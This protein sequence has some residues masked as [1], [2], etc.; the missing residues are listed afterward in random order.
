MEHYDSDEPGPSGSKAGHDDK[1]ERVTAHVTR[2]GSSSSSNNEINDTDGRY[3]D[4]EGNA[5]E[6]DSA[7]DGEQHG[8]YRVYKRRFFGLAQLVLLNIVDYWAGLTFAAVSA[9]S[10]EFFG[11]SQT[12]INWLSTSYLFAFVAVSPLVI[13]TLNRG[14]PKTSIMVSSALILVGNWIRY[15]GS[16]GSESS[17]FSVVMLGQIM[18]GIAQPFILSAPTR[19][20]NL[21]FSD[22]GRV[23]ATAIAS[24]ANPLGGAL[25]QLIG[26]FW[27]TSPARV[28]DM[29]L[30]TC[31][32]STV[33]SVPSF[34]IPAAPPTPPSKIAAAERL[35]LRAAFRSLPKISSFW[36]ILSPFSV[37][38]GFF[39][40]TASLVNQ[41]FEPYGFSETD[42]GIAGGLLI[43]V[44]LIASAIVSPLVD[45]WKKHLLTIK[46]LVPLIASGYLIL[47]FMPQTGSLVGPYFVFSLIG[48]TSF[49]L[50]PCVLEYL[51]LVTHP[52]S[53]EISSTICWSGGQLL[54]AIFIIIMGQLKGGV[55]GEPKESL[56]RGL[57][58][59]AVI[60]W[61]VVPSALLLGVWR[62]KGES[63]GGGVA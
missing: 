49:S 54:G 47:V 28:P 52:V 51:V 1:H 12:A 8:E 14:G 63:G 6:I 22:S 10:A 38:V 53:P 30:Y 5:S 19:Y 55:E 31:I 37:Y 23:T 9:T 46:I 43:I 48:A 25:G 45:R 36:L 50:L 40:A 2:T 58:F 27:A 32:L 3:H 56:K 41:I 60:A 18:L 61:V 42:A 11:V 4:Y 29:I 13:L 21:W 57:I 62:F 26:P 7:I 24:L 17:R 59:Q 15:A 16:R 34:F 20:S 33:A 39:N 44:G 35:H